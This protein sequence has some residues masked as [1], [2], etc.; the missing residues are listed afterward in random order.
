[1][2]SY[3]NGILILL[4]ESREHDAFRLDNMPGQKEMEREIKR[5]YSHDTNFTMIFLDNRHLFHIQFVYF[6]PMR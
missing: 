6:I 5:T 3:P 4:S 1:M 2:C